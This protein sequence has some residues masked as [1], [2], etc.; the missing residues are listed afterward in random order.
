VLD[1]AGTRTGAELELD[2]AGAELDASKLEQEREHEL[3]ELEL[4]SP[5]LTMN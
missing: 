1:L 5:D 3:G 2:E 4:K